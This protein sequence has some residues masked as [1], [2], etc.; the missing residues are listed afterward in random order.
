[1]VER[2]REAVRAGG[3]DCLNLELAVVVR[4]LL[5]ACEVSLFR[6]YQGGMVTRSFRI[7]AALLAS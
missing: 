6:C 3:D 1:M 5:R 2:G 7:R 4:G